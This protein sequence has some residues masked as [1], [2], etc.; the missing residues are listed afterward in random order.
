LNPDYGNIYFNTQS[1]AAAL[2][3]INTIPGA[4]GSPL[5]DV[6]I[7]HGWRFVLSPG[8]T[9]TLTFVTS[10][11]APLTGFFTQQND[12]SGAV[13]RAYLQSWMT[14]TS[15]TEPTFTMTSLLVT[16]DAV[17]VPLRRVKKR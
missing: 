2:D 10:A 7:A 3:N 11:R 17:S 1:G 14:V 13:D 6:S 16:A 4:P 9:A 12:R 5:D 8:E 15:T